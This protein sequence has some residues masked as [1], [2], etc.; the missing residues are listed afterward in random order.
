MSQGK[1]IFLQRA[2]TQTVQALD[3][4][5]RRHGMRLKWRLLRG[6]KAFKTSQTVRRE[7][8]EARLRNLALR[9]TLM[10]A[11]LRTVT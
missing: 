9:R 7:M 5:V 11:R 6:K 1:V 4:R 2:N 8:I 3:M 10:R